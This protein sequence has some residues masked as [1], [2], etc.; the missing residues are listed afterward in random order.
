MR[1][2]SPRMFIFL[3]Q[4][5]YCLHVSRVHAKVAK[6]IANPFSLSLSISQP[7]INA[8]IVIFSQLLSTLMA[9]KTT[10][11]AKD[12]CYDGTTDFTIWSLPKISAM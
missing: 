7:N 12:K 5:K 9:W 4:E 6:E 8:T 10:F 3:Q 2:Q 11:K 1:Q